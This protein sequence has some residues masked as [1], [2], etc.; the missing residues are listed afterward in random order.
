[1]PN[2]FKEL[3]NHCWLHEPHF[4]P[5]LSRL[6]KVPDEKLAYPVCVTED[7]LIY[8]PKTLLEKPLEQQ[9][10]LMLHEIIHVVHQHHA[11]R[12]G[13]SPL[14]WN[15]AADFCVNS[16]LLEKIPLEIRDNLYLPD[17]YSLP[18]G[19]TAEWYYQNIQNIQF[20]LSSLPSHAYWYASHAPRQLPP[21]PTSAPAPSSILPQEEL[22]RLVSRFIRSNLTANRVKSRR[23]LS[24][25]HPSLPGKARIR[26]KPTLAVIL[27]ISSSIQTKDMSHF[28]RNITNVCE[29]L[30][31]QILIIEADSAVRK[32]YLLKEKTVAS[33]QSGSNTCFS[34]ALQ[35]IQRRSQTTNIGCAIYF[36]D[37][38]TS[39]TTVYRP[40]IPVI[41]AYTQ[42][43]T[44]PVEW[45]W[46]VCL[47]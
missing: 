5:V 43:Y 41:W 33:V 44:K 46:H 21:P 34:P 12:E 40:S 20:D 13:R 39:E 9:V 10:F 36:T 32:S 7:Q 15:V 26:E 2:S 16:L 11:R 30:A 14:L 27:D 24:R 19:K 3:V 31:C 17:R 38:G 45:G 22:P 47:D 4:F 25:R 6:L 1:M 23:K 35:E 29:K 8:N 37:G 28:V 42:K 18:L